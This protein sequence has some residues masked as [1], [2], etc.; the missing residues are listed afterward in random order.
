MPTT[1]EI[2]APTRARVGR[3]ECRQF[4]LMGENFPADGF[5]ELPHSSASAPGNGNGSPRRSTPAIEPLSDAEREPILRHLLSAF[6]RGELDAY[7]YTRRVQVVQTATSAIEMSAVLDPQGLQVTGD[8]KRAPLD[9][10]DLARMSAASR[11]TSRARTSN[12]YVPLVVVVV[13]FVMLVVMGMWLVGHVR[14]TSSTNGAS[15]ASYAPASVVP[16]SPLSPLR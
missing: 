6:E 3:R 14:A 15:A 10:V 5:G 1:W 8:P 11:G 7:E 9:P 4:S 13:A 12:R 16:P 2:F